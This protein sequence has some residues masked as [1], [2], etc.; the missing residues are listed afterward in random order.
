MRLKLIGTGIAALSLLA[1]TF[2]AEAADIPRPVYKGVRSVVAYYNWTGFYAGVNA[3]YGWGTSNWDYA[4]LAG[5]GAV[6][7]S[8]KGWLFGVTLGYNWQAGSIVY[9]VEGDFDWSNV[10]GTVACTGFDCETKSRW[11]STFRGRLGYAMD[12]WM[13]YLTGGLAYGDVAASSTNPLFPGTSA[14][15]LGWTL[16]AGIEYALMGNWTAKLEYLY[17][18]LGKFDCGISCGIPGPDNV[19]FKENIVRVGLNYKFGGPVFSRY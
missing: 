19:S 9:G 3:G 8:P 16:G 17:V 13:P 7:N 2:S 1:T 4:F 6:S 10:K 12:R 14:R 18:D 5:T 15:R 11:L